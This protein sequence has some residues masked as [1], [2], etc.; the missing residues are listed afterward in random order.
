MNYYS[1]TTVIINQNLLIKWLATVNTSTSNSMI[2]KIF[3]TT[4]LF[5]T[6]YQVICFEITNNHKMPK[7]NLIYGRKIRMSLFINLACVA[8]FVWIVVSF[9]PYEFCMQAIRKCPH[10]KFPVRA[11]SYRCRLILRR[12]RQQEVRVTTISS[13]LNFLKN[14][15][16]LFSRENPY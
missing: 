8:I 13:F 14:C 6:L 5:Y 2:I 11:K 12:S 10:N 9:H 16:R 1:R 4:Y 15:C 3:D 7:K